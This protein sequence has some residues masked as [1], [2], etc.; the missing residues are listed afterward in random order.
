[1]VFK[2]LGLP[3][4][5]QMTLSKNLSLNFQLCQIEIGNSSSLSDSLWEL[6]GMVQIKHL[7]VW[8]LVRAQLFCFFI[9]EDPVQ[10]SHFCVPSSS[11][12][13]KDRWFSSL[14]F[15]CIFLLFK[16]LLLGFSFSF[17]GNVLKK[18]IWFSAKTVPLWYSLAVRQL[19]GQEALG[20]GLSPAKQLCSAPHWSAL[21]ICFALGWSTPLSFGPSILRQSALAWA[22]LPPLGSRISGVSAEPGKHSLQSS[23]ERENVPTCQYFSVFP[24]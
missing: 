23:V 19:P 5:S 24:I 10:M 3:C 1:M 15:P 14:G 17:K 8:P 22:D 9:F 2:I 18:E 21:P 6:N 12:S 13:M 20:P 7:A 4:I 16:K 11:I